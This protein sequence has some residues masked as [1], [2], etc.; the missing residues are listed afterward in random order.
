MP[1]ICLTV[2]VTDDIA[3]SDIDSVVTG[4]LRL[5]AKD[6]AYGLI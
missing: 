5:P 6:D 2:I 3:A 1:R 4:S